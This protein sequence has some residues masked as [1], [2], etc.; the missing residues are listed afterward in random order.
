[1]NGVRV[2]VPGA[3]AADSVH[4][5]LGFGGAVTRVVVDPV[6]VVL[7]VTGVVTGVVAGAEVGGDFVELA[8]PQA[9]HTRATTPMSAPAIIP[10][11]LDPPRPTR[12]DLPSPHDRSAGGS[13]KRLQ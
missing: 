3:A 9:E 12:E 1:M 8:P 4:P 7:V 10:I 11:R 6:D 13:C 5:E 2:T